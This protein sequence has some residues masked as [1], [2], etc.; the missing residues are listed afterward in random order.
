M[1]LLTAGTLSSREATCGHLLQRLVKA[2]CGAALCNAN[3][4]H[5]VTAEVTGTLCYLFL[6]TCDTQE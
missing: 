5:H 2:P 4:I 6:V 3:N 1:V